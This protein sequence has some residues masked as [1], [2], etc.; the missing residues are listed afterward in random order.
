MSAFNRHG[1]SKN[2]RCEC[3]G[4]MVCYTTRWKN[5]EMPLHKHNSDRSEIVIYQCLTCGERREIVIE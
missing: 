4:D 3:G 5:S 2:P 1:T